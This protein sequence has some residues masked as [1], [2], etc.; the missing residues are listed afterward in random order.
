MRQ[1][2]SKFYF[3][4]PARS[5]TLHERLKEHGVFVLAFVSPATLTKGDKT[6]GGI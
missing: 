3:R 1:A 6:L 5:H 2:F 4:D